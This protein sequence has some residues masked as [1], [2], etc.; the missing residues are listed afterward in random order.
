LP[1]PVTW[2]NIESSSILKGF[3][4]NGCGGE[5]PDAVIGPERWILRHI[6]GVSFLLARGCEYS[7]NHG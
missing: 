5:Q 7:T 3:M 2:Q 4:P 1:L 6:F